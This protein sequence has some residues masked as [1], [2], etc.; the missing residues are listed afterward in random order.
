MAFWIKINLVNTLWILVVV[1]PITIF[2]MNQGIDPKNIHLVAQ[3]NKKQML[4]NKK[5]LTLL[6]AFLYQI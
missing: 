3:I 6:V 5:Y 2:T 4:T 1:V